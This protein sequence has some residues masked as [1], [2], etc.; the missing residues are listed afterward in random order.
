MGSKAQKLAKGTTARFVSFFLNAVVGFLLMPI[1]VHSLGDKMYGLWAVAGSFLGFYGLFD[2]GLSSAVQRYLSKALGKNDTNEANVNINTALFI[3]TAI[4]LLVL[5]FTGALAFYAPLF[6]KIVKDLALFRKIILLLGISLALGFPTRVFM[7]VLFS[8]QRQD[9]FSLVEIIKLSIRTLLI[10]YFLRMGHGILMLAVINLLSNVLGDILTFIFAKK[11]A[12]YMLIDFRLVDRAMIK[13]FGH[14]SLF[15]FVGQISDKLRFYVDNFVISAFVGLSSVTIYSIAANLTRYFI[16][17]ISCAF[18]TGML[19]PIFSGYEAKGDYHSIRE[20]LISLTRISGYISMLIGGI[21]IIFGRVL[22]ERWMGDKYLDAYPILLILLIPVIID[23]MQ[24]PSLGLLYG[25]S[26]HK[27]FSL[28]NSIEGISNLILSLILV[29]KFGLIGV[30]VG[31]A[32]PMIIVKLFIQPVYVC[33]FINLNLREY[34]FSTLIPVI[35]KSSVVLFVIKIIVEK[36]IIANY[37]GIALFAFFAAVFFLVII[38]F[39]GVNS[40]ERKEFRKIFMR[41]AFQSID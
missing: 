4:C 25:I 1:I 41:Q 16:E 8:H 12:R 35:L 2:F 38:Y 37:L 20:K 27:F 26:K 6:E 36:F 3:F 22:I 9:L 32:I 19:L 11:I 5:V 17:S 15:T 7:G 18:G 31:T 10:I 24:N 29:R 13:A 33:R 21:L 28:S 40:G 34:Y 23:M 30:A 39:W 14:Y